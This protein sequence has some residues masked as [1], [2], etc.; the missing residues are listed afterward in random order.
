MKKI[1]KAMLTLLLLSSASLLFTQ[2]AYADTSDSALLEITL[3]ISEKNRAAAVSVYQKYRQPFLDQIDGAKA[4]D[5]LVRAQDVQ[6]LHE[7]KSVKSAEA[8]LNSA[9]FTKD[10]VG[11]LAPLLNANPN[12][13][14]YAKF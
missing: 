5:L 14:I 2:G 6:V 11:E 10:V 4:K 1:M 7:F 9:L 13:R 12:I 8:Y 3:D